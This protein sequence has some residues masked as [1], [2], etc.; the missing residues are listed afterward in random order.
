MLTRCH[1]SWWSTSA[2][3]TEN[4]CRTLS[5]IGFTTARFAFSDR[6]S[7]MCSSISSAPTYT[8][9]SRSSTRYLALLIRFDDVALLEVLEVGEADAAFEA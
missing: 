9:V 1:W 4:R 7:G 6:L 8:R 2:A 3:A 5:T